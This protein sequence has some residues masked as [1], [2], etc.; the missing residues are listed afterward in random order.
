MNSALEL[1]LMPTGIRLAVFELDARGN[2]NTAVIS[3]DQKKEKASDVTCLSD[4]IL[5]VSEMG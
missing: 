2:V 1:V 5:P 4:N 3:D